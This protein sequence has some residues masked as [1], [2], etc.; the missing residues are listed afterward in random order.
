MTNPAI[1]EC[2]NPGCGN[3]W[4]VRNETDARRETCNPCHLRT[5][6]NITREP[7]QGPMLLSTEKMKEIKQL[8]VFNLGRDAARTAAV[9]DPRLHPDSGDRKDPPDDMPG[10]LLESARDLADYLCGDRVPPETNRYDIPH[11]TVWD[12]AYAMHVVRNLA[13]QLD[14]APPEVP[15]STRIRCL[16]DLINLTVDIALF[17]EC[18]ENHPL[19]DQLVAGNFAGPKDRSSQ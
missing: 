4:E 8:E 16:Q 12:L 17:S 7:Y 1:K 14:E 9:I 5:M 2:S 15:E 10:E 11:P 19:L 3:T 18:R 13:L 6:A